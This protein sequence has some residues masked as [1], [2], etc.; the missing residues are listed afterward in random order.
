M[1]CVS[2]GF[3]GTQG[4][5]ISFPSVRGDLL[6]L[7]TSSW[8]VFQN[9]VSSGDVF[10]LK[11]DLQA[12]SEHDWEWTRK[13]WTENRMG[14]AHRMWEHSQRKRRKWGSTCSRFCLLVSSKT[15]GNRKWC[16]ESA[17][18]ITGE[19]VIIIIII[20][21]RMKDCVDKHRGRAANKHIY[22]RQGHSGFKCLR[23]ITKQMITF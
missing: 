8:Y 13:E 12:I 19:T 17:A 18:F 14:G 5:M 23:M 4:N 16:T 21:V 20:T 2:L 7:F 6:F 22:Y 3:G 1:S 11:V 10:M 15:K 9:I